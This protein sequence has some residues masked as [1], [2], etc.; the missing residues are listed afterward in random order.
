MSL[1]KIMQNI[2]LILPDTETCERATTIEECEALAKELGLEDTTAT[3]KTDERWPP[4]C[5]YHTWNDKSDGFVIKQAHL[6]FNDAVDG[7]TWPCAQTP[8][9]V[10]KNGLI[11]GGADSLPL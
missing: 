3:L 4:Y 11:Q 2:A 6:F 8:K 9:C 5:S 1:L 10:C 7:N